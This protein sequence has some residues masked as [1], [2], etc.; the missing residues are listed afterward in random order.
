MTTAKNEIHTW[1]IRVYF[2]SECQPAYNSPPKY[3]SKRGVGVLFF[4]RAPAIESDAAQ[5]MLTTYEYGSLY[6]VFLWGRDEYLDL[7]GPWSVVLTNTGTDT[8]FKASPNL[9]RLIST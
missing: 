2:E 9:P 4:N 6:F 3:G 1:Y 5:E 7:C 8:S